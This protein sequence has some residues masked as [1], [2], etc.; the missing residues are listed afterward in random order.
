[1]RLLHGGVKIKDGRFAIPVLH[2]W[3]NQQSRVT[4]Q[5]NYQR[6]LNRV[7]DVSCIRAVV[8]IEQYVPTE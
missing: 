1:M 7:D 6:L 5:D 8:G 4:E 2:L 3:H